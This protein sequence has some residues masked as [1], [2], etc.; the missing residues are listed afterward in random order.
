[1]NF[2]RNCFLIITLVSSALVVTSCKDPTAFSAYQNI[3]EVV[4]THEEFVSADGSYKKLGNF[5]DYEATISSTEKQSIGDTYEVLTGYTGRNILEATGDRKILVV[6]VQFSDFTINN[7]G[8]KPEEYISNLNKAFFGN[9][10]NNKFVSVAEYYNKSSYGKLRITGKV[11]DQFYTYPKTVYEINQKK[12]IRDDVQDCYNKVLTWYEDTYHESLDDYR[13]DPEHGNDDIA[14]Y[15]VYTYPTELNKENPKFFW[16][17]TFQDKPLSWS[18][19]SCMNTL[20]GYPDAHTFIHETGHL[21]G[22]VD[23][24]PT[25]ENDSSNSVSEPTGRIDMMD[26]S[27]G[28]HSALSKMWLNW[29]RPYWVTGE[30]D[31]CEI[32]IRALVDSGDMILINDTWNGTVFDEYYLVEFYSPTGLNYFDTNTGNNLAKLPTLPGVKIYHVD[33]RLGY[34]KLEN[35]NKIFSKQYCDEAG[36]AGDPV[37][38]PSKTTKNI[39]IVHDN[40]TYAD[41]KEEEI[42]LKNNLYELE[43][44]HVGHSVAGCATNLNL[45]KKGDVFEDM[46]F[47]SSK[48]LMQN[49]K[50]SVTGISYRD[51]TIKIEKVIE[52]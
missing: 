17:Y 11:C 48:L 33:A 39:N 23:Y 32:T 28:D 25:V 9:A 47:N 12:T 36:K 24:Y 2:K 37:I 46:K 13:I 49:Y 30:T 40:S 26:C 52:K 16:A 4:D 43:L 45:F 42:Y 44:N 3:E 1:M 14:I 8:V 27:V 34:Y 29:A 35:N 19:Y 7:L 5:K 41:V 15:L 50:I 51:A 10:R 22:L 6:P 38:T 21:F 20:A 31:S 18:S